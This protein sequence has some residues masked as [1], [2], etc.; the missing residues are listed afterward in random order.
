MW[1]DVDTVTVFWVIVPVITLLS[2]VL[3]LWVLPTPRFTK[4]KVDGTAV[5]FTPTYYP[6][7]SLHKPTLPVAIPLVF[8]DKGATKRLEKV[9]KLT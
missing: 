8:P 2:V 5:L 4:Y 6:S 7:V 9:S 3:K 1:E